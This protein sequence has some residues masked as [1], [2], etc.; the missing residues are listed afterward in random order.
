MAYGI[1]ALDEYQASDIG[2]G[3]RPKKPKNLKTS[4]SS[5]FG[6]IRQGITFGPKGFRAEVTGSGDLI[7]HAALKE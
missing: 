1:K 6:N 7:E 3:G 4:Q 2:P 5:H